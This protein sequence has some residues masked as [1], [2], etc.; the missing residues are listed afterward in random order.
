MFWKKKK[1]FID[2]KTQKAILHDIK[3]LKNNALFVK[4]EC[5]K[6]IKYIEEL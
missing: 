6:L 5:E 4:N 3:A 1:K 2:K